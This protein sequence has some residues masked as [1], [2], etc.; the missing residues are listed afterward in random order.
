MSTLD[1]IPQDNGLAPAK[2]REYTAHDVKR[3]LG[4]WARNGKEDNAIGRSAIG[5]KSKPIHLVFRTLN[6]SHHSFNVGD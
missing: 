2:P 1:Y 6:T 4:S 5:R 3:S